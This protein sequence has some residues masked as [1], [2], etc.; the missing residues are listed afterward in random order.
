MVSRVTVSDLINA[1]LKNN[2][3]SWVAHNQSPEI[4]ILI[5]VTHQLERCVVIRA[6]TYMQLTVHCTGYSVLSRY[7]QLQY[8]GTALIR[9]HLEKIVSMAAW[10]IVRARKLG[11]RRRWH[12]YYRGALIRTG[13]VVSRVLWQGQSPGF[14]LWETKYS[15]VDSREAGQSRAQPLYRTWK[16]SLVKCVTVFKFGSICTYVF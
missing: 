1:P 13:T 4:N 5:Q 11:F 2:Y 8:T 16:K 6:R 9:T 10:R 15:A 7:C 3:R 12:V 14:V